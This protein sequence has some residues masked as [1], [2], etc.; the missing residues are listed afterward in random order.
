MKYKIFTLIALVA[1]LFTTTSCLKDDSQT[2]IAT[3]DDT[4]ITSF[5]LGAI[6]QVVDTIGKS[7]KDST[8]TKKLMGSKCKFYI[9]Q[10]NAKI[11]NTDSLPYG[12][13][14]SAVLAN[15]KTKNGG[16]IAIKSLTNE[17]FKPYSN[18]DSIDFSKDRQL[19]VYANSGKAYRIYTVTLNVKKQKTNTAIWTSVAD[20]TT[21]GT[22]S[23]TKAASIGDKIFVAG[24]SDNATKLFVTT[25]SDGKTWT[26]A[27]KTFSAS[28]YKNLV[29]QGAT[30]F[31]LDNN[32]VLSSID[33]NTWS[34]M[35]QD[36][37]LSSLFATSSSLYAVTTDGKIKA[38]R[39]K[40][41]TW[42][43]ETLS[44]SVANLPTDNIS[45][46]L[47]T[48]NSGKDLSRV[49]LVGTSASNK[50]VEWT[51]LVNTT[52]ASISY[53][54]ATIDAV[55]SYRLPAYKCL[56][57]VNYNNLPLA[58]GLT[59]ENKIATLLLSGDQGITWKSNSTYTVPP[60]KDTA[61]TLAATVDKD[62]Y[63][64]V[65]SGNKVWKGL[66]R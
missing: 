25:T 33:G 66:F 11:Y 49:L 20:N 41:K 48:T 53:N 29:A 55:S 28:A 18:T 65:I 15:I 8:Y 22:L 50:V 9:D 45:S 4:A 54:W 2:D 36:N 24:V 6:K 26:T 38:S 19:Y 17:A 62:G 1:P 64:W 47:F 12:T 32:Q 30:L 61:N 57:V 23:A 35:G 60:T 21:L 42:T 46:A 58:L 31:I 39:D 59:S 13:K 37:T 51:R 44:G 5:S 10:A 56:T 34:V 27:T 3:Y 43:E 52:N 14:T 40:G 7:G 16:V 63:L